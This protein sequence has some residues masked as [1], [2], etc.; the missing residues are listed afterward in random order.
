M[1]RKVG[2][3]MRRRLPKSRRMM[4][5]RSS[6]TVARRRIVPRRIRMRGTVSRRGGG[7]QC[8]RV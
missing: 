5:K 2:R 8:R 1:S 4:R 7:T 3:R 6:R